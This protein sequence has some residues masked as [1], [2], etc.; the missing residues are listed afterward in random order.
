MKKLTDHEIANAITYAM[1]KE[2]VIV[3][4]D[5]E[6]GYYDVEAGDPESLKQFVLCVLRELGFIE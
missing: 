5:D 2:P 4:C 3:V 1:R 6:A